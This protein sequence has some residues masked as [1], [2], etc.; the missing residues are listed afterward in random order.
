[1]TITDI[2]PQELI[3]DGRAAEIL[4]LTRSTLATWRSLGRGPAFVKLGRRVFYYPADLREYIAAQ[5][6]EPAT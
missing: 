4:R 2:N 6:R 1:V 5:R 3:P